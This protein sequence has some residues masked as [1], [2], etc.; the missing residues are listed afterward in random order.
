MKKAILLLS[1]LSF[2][3]AGAFATFPKPITT[4]TTDIIQM[5]DA[6]E[7]GADNVTVTHSYAGPRHWVGSLDLK[8]YDGTQLVINNVTGDA[9]L[10]FGLNGV[11][12]KNTGGDATDSLIIT[13][14]GEKFY[15]MNGFI[16]DN[17]TLNIKAG[18]MYEISANGTH[19]H[20]V[21]AQNNATVYWSKVTPKAQ[22]MRFIIGT[23]GSA[24]DTNSAVHY[25][26]SSVNYGNQATLTVYNGSFTMHD[27]G[28]RIN[29][30]TSN[31]Y[32][33][34][35]NSYI[36]DIGLADN[37]VV[38]IGSG[39]TSKLIT[40]NN[41]IVIGNNA[42]LVVNSEE[43]F[44]RGSVSDTTDGDGYL[45]GTKVNV[46]SVRV[47]LYF[48]N[49]AKSANVVLGANNT[50]QSIGNNAGRTLNVTLNGN[51]FAVN[52][53]IDFSS[54]E[55][56][57]ADFENDLVKISTSTVDWQDHVTAM[58]KGVA[59]T[60]LEL[61][62]GFLFSQS[63]VVPEPSEWAFIFGALALSFAAYRRRR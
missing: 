48:T 47:G 46:S 45:I 26:L 51:M 44:Y 54:F 50:F 33:L 30:Y 63:A 37:A 2:G 15:H 59:L 62:D 14:T 24:T 28:G 39:I 31:I 4:D 60:D 7:M 19:Q 25:R 58:Y 57:I 21:A 52:N 5:T 41:N 29:L 55:L 6:L 11:T 53:A 8:G 20:R 18:D 34:S 40:T 13:N 10:Y 17:L 23:E 35:S 56:Y 12:F 49:A 43:M 32:G 1:T 22:M 3:A 27:A 16:A 9:S 38:T 61:K 36:T 42:T